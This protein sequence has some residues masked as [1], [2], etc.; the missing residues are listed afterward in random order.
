MS[1]TGDFFSSLILFI[2]LLHCVLLLSTHTMNIPCVPRKPLMQRGGVIKVNI[3][4]LHLDD[5]QIEEIQQHYEMNAHFSKLYSDDVESQ[6][7]AWHVLGEQKLDL[8][9]LADL[10]NGWS[11]RWTTRGGTGAKAYTRHL[12]LS[13][14]T[15]VSHFQFRHHTQFRLHF[16]LR[17]QFR[18]HLRLRL[19][20]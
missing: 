14:D 10:G 3:K 18:F 6:Q 1:P 13:G 12:L 5:K 15:P 9:N 7:A 8:C 20:K 19:R 17:F 2:V 16:R 11:I 4:M